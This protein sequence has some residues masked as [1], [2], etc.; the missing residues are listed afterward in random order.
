MNIE[1]DEFKE[2]ECDEF[3]DGEFDPK[4]LRE[5]RMEE[6]KFMELVGVWEPSTWEECLQK[7][8]RPPI[9]TKWVD[10]NKGR[11]GKV[12]VRSRLVARDFKVKGDDRC[13][14]VFAATPPLEMK[15]LLSRM[16]RVK[17]GVGGN[18]EDGQV[19]L[20]YIDV[21]KAHL[22]GEV[23]DSE[24]AYILL[25]EGV[26]GGVVDCG[27]GYMACGLRHR[28]GRTTTRRS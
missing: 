3:D 15:R 5:A 25:P 4:L 2:C 10:E 14:D 8:G 27:G 20:M 12:L 19:K 16:A 11:D 7:S 21:K 23:E 28:L 9:T 1:D 18:D 26:G 6:V 24:F 17:G 22:N 13:F